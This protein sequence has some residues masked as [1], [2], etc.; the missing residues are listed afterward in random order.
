MDDL[1]LAA[2]LVDE[3]VPPGRVV[4]NEAEVEVETCCGESVSLSV[5]E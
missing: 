5:T 1:P 3:I 2:V 4:E